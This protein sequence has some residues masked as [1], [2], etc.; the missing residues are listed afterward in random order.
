MGEDRRDEPLFLISVVAR[1]CDMHPQSIRLYE[2]LGLIRPR[3]ISKRRF[4]SEA[5]IERLRQI[6]RLTQEMGVNLAGVE[7]IFSLLDKI[8]Q[9]QQ[10]LEDIKAE[11]RRAT[12]AF[13]LPAS[14]D[15]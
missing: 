8:D 2:R 7:I 9:L 3:Y 12:G 13:L 1:I 11:H 14:P 10:E 6:R 4:F 5:D 15:E